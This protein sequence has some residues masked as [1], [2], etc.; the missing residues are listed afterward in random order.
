MLASFSDVGISYI[1]ICGVVQYLVS[2]LK[3]YVRVFLLCEIN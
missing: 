3:N 2:G 1:F